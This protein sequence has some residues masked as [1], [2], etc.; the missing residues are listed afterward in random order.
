MAGALV[1][2]GAVR[3]DEMTKERGGAKDECLLVARNCGGDADSIQ[4][5]IGR[6]KAEIAK[7]TDVYTP[8]EL[9]KLQSDLDKATNLL[10][11]LQNN[12]R[13]TMD[14]TL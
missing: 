5:R 14:E 4:Q 8:G 10:N 1:Y 9:R 3:A 7:G 12:D 2:S 6:L 11:Y 13:P